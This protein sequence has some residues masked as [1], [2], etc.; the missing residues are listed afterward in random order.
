[1]EQPRSD[2]D[3]GGGG[4]PSLLLYRLPV[5]T[6]RSLA[7]LSDPGNSWGYCIGNQLW[8]A[9]EL[10]LHHLVAG[11]PDQAGVGGHTGGGGGGVGGSGGGGGAGWLRGKRV[12]ELGCGLGLPGQAAAVH[13]AREVLLTD[14]EGM[15]PLLRHNV[16]ANFGAGAPPPQV[17]DA[18]IPTV[19]AG[20]RLAAA[21]ATA[22]RRAEHDSS[23]LVA[24]A[25]LDW[26]L[27]VPAA[28]NGPWD[29]ILG[30]DVA[31]HPDSFAGFWSTLASVCDESTVVLL[32]LPDRH[33]DEE[34]HLP[35]F[36]AASAGR[37]GWELLQRRR[38]EEGQSEMQLFR[39]WKLGQDDG[40]GGSGGG[41]G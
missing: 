18:E 12:L 29:V 5:A 15:M 40:G 23:L 22:G 14:V 4:G 9:A 13:G 20:G 26:N 30:S 10:L 24:T 37:F 41:D 17:A 38:F 28:C 11:E 3:S 21:V 39:V 2:A 19:G 7:V 34:S 16:S 25:P 1:M 31:Y 36:L 8:S 35:V 33:E 32:S 6:D 27:P